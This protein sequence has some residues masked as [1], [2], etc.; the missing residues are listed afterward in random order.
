MKRYVMYTILSVFCVSLTSCTFGGGQ[1]KDHK[2]KEKHQEMD[3]KKAPSH[4]RYHS[5]LSL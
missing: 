4:R 1:K 2:K 5:E 3:K